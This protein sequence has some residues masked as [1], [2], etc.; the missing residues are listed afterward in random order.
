MRNEDID[1]D[2]I[3]R[4]I[5]DFGGTEAYLFGSRARGEYRPDSD[6]DLAIKGVP[7]N[8]FYTLWS[9]ITNAADYQIDLVDLDE[10]CRFTKRLVQNE[11]LLRVL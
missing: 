6:V 11:V 7:S 4:I 10:E 3:V 5:K 9:R 1:M 2:A 8:R